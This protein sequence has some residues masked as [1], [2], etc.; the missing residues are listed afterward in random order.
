M[1]GARGVGVL[2]YLP[3]QRAH[4]GDDLP[5]LLWWNLPAKRRHAVWA[6]L[7]DSRVDVLRRLAVYPLVIHQRRTDCPSPV[8]V[9]ALAVEPLVKLLALG[10]GVGIRRVREL[11][12]LGWR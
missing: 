8:G 1:I 12:L 5:H 2:A 6:A 9:A 11:R 7:H 10:N 4:V 3:C